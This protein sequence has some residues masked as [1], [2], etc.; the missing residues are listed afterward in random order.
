MAER[1]IREEEMA[2]ILKD[3][4]KASGSDDKKSEIGKNPFS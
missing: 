2:S 1:I 3:Y 4:E